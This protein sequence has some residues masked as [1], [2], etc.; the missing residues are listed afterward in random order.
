MII[1]VV[2]NIISYYTMFTQ[3]CGVHVTYETKIY[4]VAQRWLVTSCGQLC[5]E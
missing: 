2:L 4:S 1:A 3:I 5:C